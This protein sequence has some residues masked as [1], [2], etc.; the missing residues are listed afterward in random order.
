MDVR[1]EVSPGHA[2]IYLFLVRS[3]GFRTWVKNSTTK[4]T[5]E[6][7]AVATYVPLVGQ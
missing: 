2:G 5:L 4:L 7:T 6:L 1:L 3:G